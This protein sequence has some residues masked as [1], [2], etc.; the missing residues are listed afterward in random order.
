MSKF[1]TVNLDNHVGDEEI[2]EDIKEDI[3]EEGLYC[4][5]LCDDDFE[6]SNF[7]GVN[8]EDDEFFMNDDQM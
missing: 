4:E 6:I 7:G 8:Q 2:Y 5:D 1:N 3:R